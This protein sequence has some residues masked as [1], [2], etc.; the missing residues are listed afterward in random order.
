MIYLL[1]FVSALCAGAVNAVA[2]GGTLLTFPALS[3][4]AGVSLV[5]ANA[6]S[7]IALLPGSLAG[8]WGYRK[9]LSH[10][11]KLIRWLIL[12]SIL[13]GVFGALLV[14][15]FQNEFKV[16]VPYLILLAAILFALQTTLKR[17]AKVHAEPVPATG[18]RLILII[19][20]Q[21][22]IALYGG[23]FGAGI[24]ILM[25]SLLP[26]MG[27]GEIHTTN[28][29]K[30]LL[31]SII[32]L[33]SVFVFIIDAE[34]DWNYAATMAIASIIGGYCAARIA[35]KLPAKV[36]RIIVTCIGFGLSGYY[37]FEPYLRGEIH[38]KP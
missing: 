18:N 8:A 21:F 29:A 4:G 22:L 6:T 3:E 36:I 34:I 2:G 25:L 14:T 28:A 24:G 20:A 35:R 17:W 38:E 5:I 13:G 7:T 30:T 19:F 31:A 27:T 1:L 16:I 12:P 23:Y 33:S 15:R 26:F 32:N 10:T 37:F 9:E 11:Q